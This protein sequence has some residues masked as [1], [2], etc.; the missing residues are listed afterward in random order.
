M[1]RLL[2]LVSYLIIGFLGAAQLKTLNPNSV[3]LDTIN[4]INNPVDIWKIDLQPGATV[5][6][7]HGSDLENYRV[8]FYMYTSNW[9]LLGHD[10]RL[11]EFKPHFGTVGG[12]TYYLVVVALYTQNTTISYKIGCVFTDQEKYLN[13][14]EKHTYRATIVGG[15]I[16]WLFLLDR[17]A[18][19]DPDIYVY[20]KGRKVGESTNEE[21]LDWIEWEISTTE[22]FDVEI[23]SARGGG[24]YWIMMLT[25]RKP[26]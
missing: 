1:R 10:A 11:D 12:G 22:E 16:T 8:G 25:Y 13:P 6:F 17:D 15:T 9:Q 3:V 19:F 21:D 4:P 7:L 2:F 26:I 24:R 14:G 20:Y 23:V 5:I 18:N